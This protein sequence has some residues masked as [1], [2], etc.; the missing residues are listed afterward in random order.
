MAE[1]SKAT[2]VVTPHSMGQQ[3]DRHMLYQQSVQDPG[4]EIELL[5]EKFVQLRARTPL[6]FREDFCGTAYL[7]VAWC[8]SDPH[9]TAFGVDWD[10]ETLEWGR[11]HNLEPAGDDVARRVTLIQGDVLD[12]ETPP[13]DLVCAFNFSYNGFKRREDLLAYFRAAHRALKSDGILA[14]DVYGGTEAIDV[15]EEEREIEGSDISYVWDQAKFDPITHHT[16]CHIHFDFPDGSR[17]ERAFSYEWRLWSLPELREL[18]AEAG[19]SRTRVYWE[20]FEDT[21]DD[22]YLEGTGRYVESTEV[23]NQESWIAYLFAEA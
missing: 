22:E 20:E 15:L 18:L 14:M 5:T 7:A 1:T 3:A 9:R 23:E 16:V 10:R 11:V 12:T 8:K 21:D 6:S 13:V 4:T 19:F 2:K 17:L